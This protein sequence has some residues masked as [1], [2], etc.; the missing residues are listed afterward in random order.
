MNNIL[1]LIFVFC[2]SIKG[3]AQESGNYE[4]TDFYKLVFYE[5]SDNNYGFYETPDSLLGT[6]K[7]SY[8]ENMWAINL[9]LLSE[10]SQFT[11]VQS[12][13]YE[14]SYSPDTTETKQAFTETLK[15]DNV[16][17]TIFFKAF[18]Q[19]PVADIGID[20]LQKIAARFIYLHRLDDGEITTLFCTAINEVKALKQ[21]A[22]SPYYNAFCYS[23]IR[24][25]TEAGWDKIYSEMVNSSK[26]DTDISDTDL[27][28]LKYQNYKHFG[29]SNTFRKLILAE[30][31]KRKNYLNFKVLIT[32]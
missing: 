19:V 4:I 31:E 27:D 6:P 32:E 29:V 22:A 13:W 7:A 8:G 21:T 23:V 2:I 10:Y 25:L 18:N 20:S 5:I 3:Y 26:I 24:N 30:Y 11:L 14:D 12:N 9:Y 15:K 28:K 16:F 17:K 1:V